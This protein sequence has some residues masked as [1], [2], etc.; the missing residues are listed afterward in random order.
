MLIPIKI[1]KKFDA[2]MWSQ[3]VVAN[4]VTKNISYV[5]KENEDKRKSG[6]IYEHMTNH[7]TLVFT[8]ASQKVKEHVT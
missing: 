1:Q 3:L 7:C 2:K 6:Y 8:E 5:T 4:S